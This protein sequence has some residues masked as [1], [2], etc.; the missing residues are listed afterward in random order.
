MAVNKQNL[1][2]PS[3]EVARENGRKGGK[4]KAE[5]A[6]K[7]KALKE[8]LEILLQK[9]DE[10]GKTYQE[11]MSIAL[12][13]EA[14]KGN[15]KAYEIIRDTIGEKPKE[16]IGISGEINNP[17]AGMSTTELRKIVNGK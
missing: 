2:V 11:R 6:Q 13:K 15:T 5:N 1:I 10:D 17:F 4:K 9:L 16:N 12:I 14:F 3:S 7:R 8:E